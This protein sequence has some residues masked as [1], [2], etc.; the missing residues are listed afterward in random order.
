MDD[1]T[2]YSDTFE[3]ALGI[4]EKVIIRCQET[5]MFLSHEKFRML[6]TRRVVLGHV[7]YVAGIEVY[8]AKIEVLSNLHVPK[9]QKKN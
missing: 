8:P 7:I 4:L 9:N 1:F 2:V 3:E 6:L 5:N